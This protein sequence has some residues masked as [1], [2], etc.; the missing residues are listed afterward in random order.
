[1][2]TCYRLRDIIAVEN[3]MTFTLTFRMSQVSSNMPIK[4]PYATSDL[5]A[6][7]IRPMFHRLKIVM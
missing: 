6:I 7:D 4:S 2:F 1:M 5:M 3:S